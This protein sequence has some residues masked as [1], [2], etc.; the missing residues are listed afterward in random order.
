VE[1]EVVFE[2][3]CSIP[4]IHTLDLMVHTEIVFPIWNCEELS[5]KSSGW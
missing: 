5:T 3:N 4:I 2:F 1:A